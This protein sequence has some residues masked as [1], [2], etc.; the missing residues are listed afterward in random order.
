MPTFY[1]SRSI[2][3]IDELQKFIEDD[4]YRLSLKLEPNAQSATGPSSSS[5]KES[6]HSSRDPKPNLMA[7]LNLSP[8]KGTPSSKIRYA[9]KKDLS[10]LQTFYQ[11]KGIEEFAIILSLFISLYV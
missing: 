2:R 11:S 4:N 3:Y 9:I 1:H 7:E 10:Q 5:S 8:A 6:V